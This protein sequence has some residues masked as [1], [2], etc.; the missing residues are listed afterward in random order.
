MAHS[1]RSICTSS[2]RVVTSFADAIT[3]LRVTGLRRWLRNGAEQEVTCAPS[4]QVCA[5]C[6]MLSQD[7][8]EGVA[9]GER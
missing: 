7:D 9:V 6:A 5:M 8:R 3:G 4:W 1:V 2:D